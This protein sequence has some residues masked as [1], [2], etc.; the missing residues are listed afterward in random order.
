VRSFAKDGVNNSTL[1]QTDRKQLFDNWAKNYDPATADGAFPFAGYDQILDEVVLL[2]AI[3]PGMHILD[4]GI[5]TG[6]LAR[7]F[8]SFG[9]EV[10][11]ADF[12]IEMLAQTHLR[13]PQIHLV[14]IDLLDKWPDEIGLFDCVVSAYV[15]HEFD[16]AN[17]ISLLRRIVKNHLAPNGRIIIA[18]VAFLNASAHQEASQRWADKW[19][20]DEYYWA[21]DEAI[22]AGEKVGLHIYYRQISA[23]GGIFNIA[24]QKCVAR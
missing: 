4:L 12:S 14:K 3:K 19:D 18:D 9:C 8:L 5:G 11:G 22:A 20:E 6:N 21:A 15:F 13:F 1:S 16:L 23:C 24:N 7:R 10:W 2:A 17:K